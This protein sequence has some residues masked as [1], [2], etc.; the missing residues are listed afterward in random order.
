MET[1]RLDDR[2]WQQY[3][4]RRMS[5]ISIWRDGARI[6]RGT[7]AHR[8]AAGELKRGGVLNRKLA[9]SSGMPYLWSLTMTRRGS[10]YAG[11]PSSCSTLA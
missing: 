2:C 6:H 3:I 7:A 4:S 8:F 5:T 9:H 11:T 1:D 10:T